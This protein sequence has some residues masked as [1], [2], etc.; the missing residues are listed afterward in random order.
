MSPP[1]DVI[2]RWTPGELI[3]DDDDGG[4]LRLPLF[5][6]FDTAVV[7]LVKLRVPVRDCGGVVGWLDVSV[8]VNITGVV[9]KVVKITVD[10]GDSGGNVSF[11]AATLND[12]FFN[13]FVITKNFEHNQFVFFN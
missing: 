10:G 13:L 6:C 2:S 7:E 9:S 5:C 3:D 8:T 4:V 12:F 11:D 1:V